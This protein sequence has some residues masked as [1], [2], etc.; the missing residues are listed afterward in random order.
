MIDLDREVALAHAPCAMRRAAAIRP[1]LSAAASAAERKADASARS[2]WRTVQRKRRCALIL[3]AE[4]AGEDAVIGEEL[5]ATPGS[6]GPQLGARSDRR[7][8]PGSSQGRPLVRHADRARDRRAFPC[9]GVIDQAPKSWASA[10]SARSGEPTAARRGHA[11][12]AR[13]RPRAA[14]PMRRWR[15]RGAALSR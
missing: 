15:P 14:R 3:Q 1:P 5:G 4:V 12:C 8:D 10:G 13:A 7:D 9:S 11:A 2:R 6:I